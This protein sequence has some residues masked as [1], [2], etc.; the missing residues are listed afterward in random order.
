MNLEPIYHY[1]IIQGTDEWVQLRKA[2]ITASVISTFL[3]NGK[4][5]NGFGKGAMTELL[6]IVEE[7]LT[8]ETRPNFSTKATDFGNDNEPLNI[9]HYENNTF[10]KVK[11]VGFVSRGQW[12]GCSPDGLVGA[13]G[14]LE[15]KCLPKEHITMIDTG[16]CDTHK[17]HVNQCQFNLYVTLRKWWDLIYFHPKFPEKSRSRIFRIYP[18]KKLFENFDERVKSF[19][20]MIE[21][22]IKKHG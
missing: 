6:R 13:D 5:E 18:D 1:D 11:L 12:L 22:R 2:R 4:F 14:G 7:V 20:P 19:I 10:Q 16:T 9:E 8:G 21:S 3:V 15:C 17:Y